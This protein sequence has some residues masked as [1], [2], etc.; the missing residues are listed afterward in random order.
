M[1]EHNQHGNILLVV[2]MIGTLVSLMLTTLVLGPVFAETSAVETQLAEL[3]ARWAAIGDFRYA[4]SRI[5]HSK[6]CQTASSCAG[7]KLTDVSK[8]TVL[9]SYLSEISS[10]QNWTYPEEAS[11]YTINL[12]PTAAQDD[13][14][15]KNAYSGRLM[16]KAGYAV[17]QSSLRLLSGATNRMGPFELRLC[18]GLSLSTSKCGTL[19]TDNGG[20]QTSFFSVG[21]LT[22]LPPGS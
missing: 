9:Q 5:Y 8:A 14:T 21:R 16:I 7:T 18:V 2:M 4:M 12:L 15:G 10:Y 6:L 13:T 22:R 20:A 1:R 11:S 17:G 3:R 19:G